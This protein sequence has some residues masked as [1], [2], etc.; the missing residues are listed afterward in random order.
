MSIGKDRRV[1]GPQE[2]LRVSSKGHSAGV[3]FLLDENRFAYFARHTF[4]TI[5]ITSF[6]PFCLSTSTCVSGTWLPITCSF[7]FISSISRVF[8]PDLFS[9]REEI[10]YTILF[11]LA[12]F[13]EIIII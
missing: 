1:E 9:F 5:F 6:R 3:A 2:G 10:S 4:H 7:I 12:R 8:L 13:S 11:K